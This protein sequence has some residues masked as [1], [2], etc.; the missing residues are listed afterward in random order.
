VGGVLSRLELTRFL[1]AAK[2]ATFAG[3]PG[4]G[5]RTPD[6][7]YEFTFSQ[8]ELSYRDRYYG[9][10]QAVGQEVVFRTGNPIWSMNYYGTQISDQVAEAELVIFLKEALR[11]VPE[12]AP[13]RGPY[14]HQ[15]GD[16]LYT[17]EVKGDL[18]V[19]SGRERILFR[20]EEVY[21]LFYHGGRVG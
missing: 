18:D 15:R 3:A 8:G 9:Q 4:E 1:I 21:F 6:F 12:S 16:W 7:A 11:S 5:V 14:N 17:N 2:T 10:R 20:E 19:F 13:F